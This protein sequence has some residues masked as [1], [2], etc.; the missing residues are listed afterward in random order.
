MS[1][2]YPRGL[3]IRLFSPLASLGALLCPNLWGHQCCRTWSQQQGNHLNKGHIWVF[4]S[5]WQCLGSPNPS[6][7]PC[8]HPAH[9]YSPLPPQKLLPTHCC[10]TLHSVLQS[11][12]VQVPF[13]VFSQIPGPTLL[14]SCFHAWMLC[15]SRASV[16]W[17]AQPARADLMSWNSLIAAQ[18]DWLLWWSE[19][20]EGAPLLYFKFPPFLLPCSFRINIWTIL[21]LLLFGCND[22]FLNYISMICNN[23]L[24]IPKI[25]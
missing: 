19:R 7:S 20:G 13:F 11:S 10:E 24:N 12:R 6:A 1:P 8:P 16:P 2:G 17:A 23:L 4:S 15:S 14:V 25:F 18:A 3:H 22:F 5:C 9:C 21:A